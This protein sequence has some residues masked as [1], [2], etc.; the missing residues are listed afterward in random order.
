[1]SRTGGNA[2]AWWNPPKPTACTECA[3]ILPSSRAMRAHRTEVHRPWTS[4]AKAHAAALAAREAK[5]A[6]RARRASA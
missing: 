4:T 2:G 3:R 6:E 1:M 5:R